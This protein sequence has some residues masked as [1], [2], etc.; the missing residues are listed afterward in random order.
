M[1]SNESVPA[2]PKDAPLSDT[3]PVIVVPPLPQNAPPSG[4]AID[5][6]VWEQIRE[7]RKDSQAEPSQ[8]KFDN[9]SASATKEPALRYTPKQNPTQANTVAYRNA[10]GSN[11]LS[12]ANDAYKNLMPNGNDIESTFPHIENPPKPAYADVRP[13]YRED[14]SRPANGEGGITFRDRQSEMRR[15]GIRYI[16]QEG[17]TVFRLATDKLK[18]STRWREIL[19]M[20]E[21]RLQDVRDLRPG[22]EILLPMETARLSRFTQ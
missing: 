14:S 12:D 21:D 19:A 20:N 7:F 2:I 5:S 6:Q 13:K 22:M 16:V 17:D 11:V 10:G 9:S 8:L 1:N 3:P 4:Q 18:D 15:T